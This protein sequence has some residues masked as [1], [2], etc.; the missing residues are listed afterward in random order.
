MQTAIISGCV[1][2][3]VYLFITVLVLNRR[4]KIY[5]EIHREQMFLRNFGVYTYMQKRLNYVDQKSPYNDFEE[6]KTCRQ[7]ISLWWERKCFSFKLAALYAFNWLFGH[8]QYDPLSDRLT[9]DN[10]FGRV[11]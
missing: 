5:E 10:R 9:F 8:C 2:V 7:K 6:P 3:I 11:C 1:G 4:V